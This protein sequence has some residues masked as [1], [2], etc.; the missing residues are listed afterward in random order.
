MSTHTHPH[1]GFDVPPWDLSEEKQ[2]LPAKEM[3][4][5]CQSL[6][7]N[8][9]RIRKRGKSAC[10]SSGSYEG[11]RDLNGRI[12]KSEKKKRTTLTDWGAEMNGVLREQAFLMNK[13]SIVI[14]AA[15]HPAGLCKP[16]PFSN[17]EIQSFLPTSHPTHHWCRVNYSAMFSF[18]RFT[19][20]KKDWGNSC[21]SI[22]HSP[23]AF[24][25]RIKTDSFSLLYIWQSCL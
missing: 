21:T 13:N 8:V 19:G 11:K 17:S 1:T 2:T 15:R 18:R 20:V 14:A 25:G 23:A 3:V 10:V 9:L 5:D 4:L 22:K 24:P 7:W 6:V 16:Q 12:I